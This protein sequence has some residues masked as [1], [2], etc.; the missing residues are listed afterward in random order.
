MFP[1]SAVDRQKVNSRNADEGRVARTVSH[2]SPLRSEQGDFH[3][4]A[5]PLKQSHGARGPFGATFGS[6][7]TAV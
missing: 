1:Q 4:S 6:E 3:H 5:P 7:R 2:P